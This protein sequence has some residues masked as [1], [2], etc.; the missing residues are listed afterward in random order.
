M[1]KGVGLV[2]LH[3]AVEPVGF[4]RKEEGGA[5]FLDWT[6][7]YYERFLSVNPHWTAEFKTFPAHPVTR[8]VKPFTVSDEWY[9]LMRFPPDM[10]NVTPILTTVPPDETRMGPDGDHSGN[11]TVRSRKGM[12][13]H[14]AWAIERPHGGRGFGFTGGHFHWNWANRGFLTVVLNAIVWTAGLDVPENGVPSKT[15][16]LEDLKADQDYPEP[17]NYDWEPVKA[18]LEKWR[19]EAAASLPK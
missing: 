10:K 1:K 8:G 19:A 15:P 5:Y 12:P 2:L 17:K 11:P 3:Y 9:Y 4:E 18:L 13:E 6:G 14:V 16:T 7:G